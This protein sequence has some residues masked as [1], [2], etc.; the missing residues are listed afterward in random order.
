MGR[1]A[2][3]RFDAEYYMTFTPMMR[4]DLERGLRPMA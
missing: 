4:A 1:D 2:K 3:A